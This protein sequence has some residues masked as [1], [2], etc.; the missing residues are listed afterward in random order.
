M[1]DFTLTLTGDEEAKADALAT[2]A[3]APDTQT[4]LQAEAD[5]R[6]AEQLDIT[7]RDWFSSLTDAERKTIYDANNP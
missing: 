4:F 1:T 5:A 6:L 2:A 7:H 3:G